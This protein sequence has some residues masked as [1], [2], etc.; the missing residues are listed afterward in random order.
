MSRYKVYFTITCYSFTFLMLIYSA[1]NG[2]GVFPTLL[3][4]EVFLLFLMTLCGSILIAVTNRLPI[5][6]PLLAAFTRVADVAVSV[7]GIGFVSGMIPM[8]WFYV[9][10][11]LGMIIVIYFGVAGVLM[12]KDKADADAINEQL[13]RRNK[14]TGGNRDE[15]DH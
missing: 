5:N 2:L 11:I 14:Q 8:E 7:F 3:A 6:N 10:T 1:L 15:H 9:L 13:S 12:I 4:A